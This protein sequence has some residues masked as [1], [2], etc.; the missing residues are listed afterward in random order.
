MERLYADRL[1][2]HVERLGHHA[3]QG[4]AWDKAAAY[5]RQAGTKA[6][7]R[8]AY[9]EAATCFERAVD[10][11]AH[12]PERRDTIEHAID[13]RLDLR[14]A[15][16][17]SG[18]TRAVHDHLREAERLAESLG[19]QRRLAAVSALLGW[20]QDLRGEHERAVESAHR[21]RAIAVELRDFPLQVTANLFLGLTCMNGGDYRGAI[22]CGRRNI[23]AL[24]GDLMTERFGLLNPPA[25]T[26][27]VWLVWSLA[28]IGEFTEGIEIGEE[29]MRIATAVDRPWSLAAAYGGI[30]QLF[31]LKGEL[32]RALSMLERSLEHS[33]RWHFP[34]LSTIY[35]AA[36]GYVHALSG[37][38]DASLPL[39]ERAIEQAERVGH[40][41]YSQYLVWLSHACLLSGR[42]DKA[43]EHAERALE[44]SRTR[45]ERG[46]QAWAHRL[47][48][49]LAS[50][51]GVEGV[52]TA[53]DSYGHAMTLATELGMRP[54][55]AHC[56][57]GLGTLFA[58]TARGDEAREH[59]T[60]ATTM[61][62]EMD[63][64][65]WLEKAE[66]E[67]EMG[68]S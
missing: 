68:T 44:L 64:R 10:A 15:L 43:A 58:K 4:E 60:T 22:E 17:A 46:G 42:K 48:G 56:H 66:A 61:Y 30:G 49:E 24:T 31:L 47:L 29:A 63:M 45:G 27:R 55:V 12:L 3:F 25:V 5:L 8:S 19:D 51:A 13:A 65:Y 9:R 32:D 23:Q 18:D 40:Y 2:E 53:K 36:L 39:L 54:L 35:S 14:H 57:L 26:S 37:R 59:L 38:L 33:E 62:R 1:A 41:R 20:A 50:E 28:E 21:A 6:A 11:L 16:V 34:L 67:N 52:T 7:G